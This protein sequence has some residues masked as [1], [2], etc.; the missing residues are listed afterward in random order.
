MISEYII[1]HLCFSAP[2]LTSGDLEFEQLSGLLSNEWHPRILWD[3]GFKETWN[4][5]LKD[6]MGF[7]MVLPSAGF[8]N[9]LQYKNL[10]DT[11]KNGAID[12]VYYRLILKILTHFVI[13]KQ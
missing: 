1:F 7:I 13:Y 9:I 4:S 2:S 12:P 11:S 3:M 6:W 10:D 8:Y 5:A